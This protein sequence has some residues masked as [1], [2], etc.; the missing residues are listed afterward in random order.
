MHLIVAI[1][2]SSETVISSAF[3]FYLVLKKVLTY[4]RVTHTL[5]L[6]CINGKPV[7][8]VK[9]TMV[10]D[11]LL[12]FVIVIVIVYFFSIAFGSC[13]WCCFYFGDLHMFTYGTNL[14]LWLCTVQDSILITFPYY[15]PKP[16]GIVSQGYVK[17]VTTFQ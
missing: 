5:T 15:L 6:V 4:W 3:S 7:Q 9:T 1:S 12:F 16:I 11:I 13:Q 17:M 14:S 8:L 10:D 2:F